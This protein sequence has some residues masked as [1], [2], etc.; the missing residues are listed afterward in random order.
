MPNKNNEQ[1][2][3]MVNQ[4]QI[5]PSTDSQ[6]QLALAK[7][8]LIYSIIGQL[9]G[10]V[11]VLGGMLLFFNGIVGTTSWTAKILGAESQITDAAPGAI[12]F[13]VGVFFVFITRYKFEHKKAK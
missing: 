1:P 7:Y 5:D 4:S 8:E 2:V 6:T 13:I 11:C 10:L 9:L 12:L 3:F